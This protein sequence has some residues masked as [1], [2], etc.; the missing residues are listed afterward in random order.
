MVNG[1]ILINLL[2]RI[3]YSSHRLIVLPP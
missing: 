2:A 1:K 3:D